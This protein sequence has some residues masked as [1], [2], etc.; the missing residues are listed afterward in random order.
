MSVAQ[1]FTADLTRLYSEPGGV[2]PAIISGIG[3]VCSFTFGGFYPGDQRLWSLYETWLRHQ[4]SSHHPPRWTIEMVP[5]LA[6]WLPNMFEVRFTDMGAHFSRFGSGLIRAIGVDLTGRRA[7]SALLGPGS[8]RID[9]DCLHVRDTGK[10]IW[11]DDELRR[12]GAS[13]IVCER[14]T[15]PFSDADGQI[16]RL[17]GCIY[18]QGNAMTPGWLGTIVRFVNIRNTVLD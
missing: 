15:L 16:N 7:A 11:S 9:T 12:R 10:V 2:S 13:P 5:D 3:D 18:L 17:V 1:S 14:L 4:D 8:E 6:F